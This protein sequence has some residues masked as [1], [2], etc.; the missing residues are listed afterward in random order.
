METDAEAVEG[1]AEPGTEA[2][3]V[4]DP[5]LS[6]VLALLLPAFATMVYMLHRVFGGGWI[7]GPPPGDA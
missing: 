2:L 7:D 3:E 6:L 4:S 1:M 5:P